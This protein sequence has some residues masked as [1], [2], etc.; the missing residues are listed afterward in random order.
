MAPPVGVP[1]QATAGLTVTFVVAVA[2]HPHASVTCKVYMP[3]ADVDAGVTD[4]DGDVLP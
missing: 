1:L 2:V 4:G 3:E